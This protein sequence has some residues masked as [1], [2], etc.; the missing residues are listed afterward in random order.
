MKTCP[1]CGKNYDDSWRICLV[2]NSVLLE[3][4]Q[5][6]NLLKNKNESKQPNS[7]TGNFL[8]ILGIFAIP[9]GT[10]FYQA[11]ALKLAID[12]GLRKYHGTD[13]TTIGMGVGIGLPGVVISFVATLVGYFLLRGS[14]VNKLAN[15][16]G[17]I[18][19]LIVLVYFGYIFNRGY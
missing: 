10:P 7:I 1:Q 9:L 4:Q 13:G 14:K 5:L 15:V 8:M 11:M 12:L 19:F 2:D 6:L 3:G 18:F 16:Y 17:G